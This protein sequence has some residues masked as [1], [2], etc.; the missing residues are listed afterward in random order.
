MASNARQLIAD[1][2]SLVYAL[3]RRLWSEAF[4]HVDYD[5]LVSLGTLGLCQSA[6]RYRDDCGTSFS[7]FAYP[8]VRGAILDGVA[9]LGPF[10]RRALRHSRLHK[11]QL[12]SQSYRDLVASP[13]PDPEHIAI[14]RQACAHL[15]GA[16]DQLGFRQKEL[17]N[18]VYWSDL[19]IKEAGQ[20]FRVSKSWASRMHKRCLDDLRDQLSPSLASVA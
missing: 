7:T 6:R 3:A 20:R 4:R 17:L 9:N 12:I 15:R 1:H 11:L 8:R 2:L 19:N 14:T 10:P 16:M 5:E 18:A 13:T